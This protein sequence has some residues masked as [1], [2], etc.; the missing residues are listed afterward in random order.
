MTHAFQPGSIV[1]ARGR[2]WIVLPDSGTEVL[3][4]R[5]VG[6]SELEATKLHV[7]LEPELPAQ[8][9]FPWPDADDIGPSYAAFLFKDAM[10]LKMRAGAGPFRSFG[11]IAIEPRAYQLVPLMMAMR[12]ETVRLL[13]ADDVGIGKTI[14]AGL[15][16]RELLDR[17]EIDRFTVLVPPHLCEQWAE[18]LERHF[19]I[20]AEV[21]RTSTVGRLERALPP[22]TSIFEAHPFTIV[23]LDYIKSDRRRDEFLRSCPGCVIVDEAH[24]CT[25]GRGR[26]RQKRYELL[27]DL[28]RDA[29]R[30]MILLTATP[31]SG[32][33]EAF[34]NLLGLLDTDFLRFSEATGSEREALRKKLA[35]HF[36]QR[37][38]P[39]IDEWHDQNLFPEKKDAE[40]TYKLT[41]DWGTLFEEVMRYARELVASSEG[42]SQFRQR[43]TWWAALALL[44]CVSSSPMAAVAALRNR[45][46]SA[47]DESDEAMARRIFDGTEEDLETEDVEPAAA[48]QERAE[49]STALQS[50]VEQALS[51]A[52]PS[53]DP[54]LKAL[55]KAVDELLKAGFRPVIFCRY[56]ATAHYVAE[57]LAK[58][59]KKATVDTV[60]GEL[61]P[62]ERQE[63]VEE[64]G[65]SETPILV[66]TD[67]LSEGINLQDYFTAVIHYDLSWNPTRHEQ[68]EG[69]VDRFGQRAKEVRAVMLYGRDNPVDGAVLEV[70]LRKARSIQRELGVM[71]PMPDDEERIT[72]ALMRTVLL[73]SKERLTSKTLF[74]ELDEEVKDFELRWESAY[75]K[76]KKNRTI[77]A[78]R[79]LKPSEVLPEWE[80]SRKALG[81]REEVERFVRRIASALDAPLQD[82]RDGTW[83]L[84]TR[85]LPEALRELLAAR[86][87][88]ETLRLDF[89]YPA[90]P[91]AMQVHRSAT[92]VSTL[93]DYAAEAALQAEPTPWIARASVFFTDVVQKRTV[94]ALV[95]LRTRLTLTRGEREH[96]VLCEE[97]LTLEVGESLTEPDDAT[98]KGYYEAAAVKNM[99]EAIQ[100]RH[101]RRALEKLQNLG[102]TLD[103][104]AKAHAEKLLE[105]H[106][107]IRDAARA[108][109]SYAIS[110]VLPVDILGIVVLVPAAKEL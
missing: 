17:G 50:L 49:T 86:E 35:L 54:K 83:L 90:A 78:Q 58:K 81:S 79:G 12:L 102:T 88:R 16:V 19:Q 93:A 25:K 96:T 43:L 27:H 28:S 82:E 69:R 3:H 30:H 59:F 39:D 107:R 60:T 72:Q 55:I 70:I 74:D 18:E 57:H 99:P 67:C 95:R 68:R 47:D 91:G 45:I 53:K 108:R 34:Y 42:E 31:H 56:I 106:R 36:V 41:G 44:R 7:A 110:P 21:V 100:K 48:L 97:A 66:A 4:L 63:R 22:G 80:K 1:S 103:E 105:D 11:N 101:L 84:H 61:T 15:I 46:L 98:L 94:L 10:L 77:F 76:A 38:R 71:V 9:V 92:L 75:E 33:D 8:A 64:L 13:I 87:L 23:S 2:E 51:L 32:D 26:A 109:G 6:G 52:T 5:P 24:T 40:V 29:R 104:L 85:Y 89:R 62:F 37:R 65:R 73:K 20:K 14:E